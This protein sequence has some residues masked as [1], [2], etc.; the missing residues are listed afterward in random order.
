MWEGIMGSVSRGLLGSLGGLGLLIIFAVLFHLGGNA[1]EFSPLVCALISGSLALYSVIAPVRAGEFV[2]PWLGY[3]RLTWIFIGCGL[4]A[5]GGGESVW[6]YYSFLHQNPFPSLADVGYASLPPLFFS[7]LLLLPSSGI[8]SRRLLMMFDSLIAMGSMLAIGWALLLGSLALA[9]G[10]DML[11]KF[12]GL[13]YPTADIALL[14]CVVL[15]FFRSRGSLYQATARRVSLIII[16]I[17]LCFFASSDFIFN[18]QQNAGTYVDG[19]WADL[20]WPLGMLAIGAAAYL[21]RFLP[22]TP[23][24]IIEQR[25]RRY[26]ELSSVGMAQLATYGILCVL[27]VVLVLNTFSAD[28]LQAAIRPVLVL[29]TIVV[30][31]LVVIRQILTIHENEQLARR[32]AN[33]LERLETA[34]R[35]VAEQAHMISDRNKELEEGINHLKDVQARIANGNVRVRA[36]LI[37]GDLLPLAV[38]LNLMAERLTHLEEANQYAQR[39]TRALQELV[40]SVEQGNKGKTFRLPP[41][42]RVFPEIRRLM[43]LLGCKEETGAPMRTP[44]RFLSQTL[45]KSTIPLSRPGSRRS[46]TLP[47]LASHHMSVATPMPKNPSVIPED[48]ATTPL[49]C[50]FTAPEQ[51]KTDEAKQG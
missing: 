12:L 27:C 34:N 43:Y 32:Q 8:G 19:T 30:I 23:G 16:G 2:E 20:G 29:A 50:S 24:D 31:A 25:L 45:K 13:Y 22:L 14:S 40:V 11:A 18:V 42:C 37:K 44:G 35:Q 21:R 26:T 41:S 1:W 47:H 49:P 36:R 10:Q 38:S 6:R 39:L 51:D 5:W 9:S 4:L 33:A 46:Q 3:E 17:G 28:S 7:G 15:L 48:N